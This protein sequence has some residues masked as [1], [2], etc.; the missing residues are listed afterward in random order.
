MTTRRRAGRARRGNALLEFVL[1][2]P[3]IIFI[4]GLTLYMSI[5]MMT[6]QTAVVEARHKLWSTAHGGWSMMRIYTPAGTDAYQM[7]PRPDSGDMPRGSGEELDRLRPEVEPST[8]ATTSNALARQFWQDTWNNLPGRQHVEDKE[9][10]EVAPMWNFIDTNTSSDHYRDS[11]VWKFYHMDQWRIARGGPV[12][13]IFDAFNN[14]IN[15]G[16]PVPEPFKK[17]RDD[18]IKRWFHATNITTDTEGAIYADGFTLSPGW[19][20]AT[21]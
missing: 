8:L 9:K 6:K 20:R 2:L 7:G 1:T 17:T 16:T 18:I 10:F 19:T 12:K 3:I 11:D 5:A 21:P 13:E 14:N 15:I 4:A